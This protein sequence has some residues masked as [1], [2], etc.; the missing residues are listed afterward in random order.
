MCGIIGYIGKKQALPILLDGLKRLEYRGYDSAGVAIL[1][2]KVHLAKVA[3]RV[4]DL[5]KNIGDKDFSG[6]VGIAHTRWATHGK[7][8][9]ANA[10]PHIGCNNDFLIVHNGI[11]ENYNELKKELQDI[12]HKFYSQTDS[13]VFA[14]LL[15]EEFKHYH[16]F[17]A[18]F[19]NAIL[20]IR[21][22]YGI[23]AIY[24]NDNEKILIA[25]KSSPILIGVGKD[26][27]IIASD[28]SALLNYTKD[29]IYLGDDEIAV[30]EINNIRISNSKN[31]AVGRKAHKID[32][33]LEQAEKGS[34]ETFMKK[35]IFES[36]D[37]IKNAIRGRLVEG[38]GISKFG[39]LDEVKD[40]L[41]DIKRIT[42]VACGTSY[43]AGLL[44]KYWISD[45]AG[46][47]TDVEIASEFKS[48]DINLGSSD[49]VIAISQSGETADTLCAVREAKKKGALTLGIVNVV[50]SSISRE[51][52]IGIY[53]HAGPEISVASTKAFISQ[54]T[55]LAL[56]TL[57]FARNNKMS[58]EEG[59]DLIYEIN[60]L[61]A[62]VGQVLG[63]QKNIQSI[64]EK[65]SKYKNFIFLGR[66]YNFP[67]ALESALKLKEISYIHA[68]GYAGGELKHGPLAMID[69]NF[70]T[71]C[72]ATKGSVYDKILSNIE[73][74]KARN[75]KVICIATAGDK[76]IAKIAD[77]V[78][79]IPKSIEMLSPI[80]SVVVTQ[81]FAYFIA[82]V[83]GRDID[84]PRNLAKSV[85]VE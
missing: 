25:R 74:I 58:V 7:P 72:I 22:A 35:E 10:H 69:K 24:K 63:Q 3:G 23:V 61:Y 83:L 73:E 33:S 45:I 59:N 27:Y 81:L 5:E 70:P 82:R 43:Y 29:I 39:G 6:Y 47:H 4:F 16:N 78:I 46:L 18:S 76:N 62:K 8:T 38:E 2:E 30:C 12:G 56:L 60:G 17:E 32:I 28:L 14:H 48:R 1:G 66:K 53:N 34:F 40:R 80:L 21:G 51:T 64:A 20:K 75:G 71:F 77:D 52:D 11:I 84:K 26:E 65:Y 9:K 54:A 19:K 41:K 67:I 37:V 79:Y 57:F 15:E 85:T 36:P 42:I 49:L 50:G 13:E 55:V 31:E 68:E 44:A